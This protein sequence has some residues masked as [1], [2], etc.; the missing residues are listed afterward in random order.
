MQ[1][2]ATIILVSGEERWGAES[3]RA[4][5]SGAG[6]RVI[7]TEVP[8]VREA[9]GHYHP[10]LVVANLSGR[11]A[12]DLDLCRA[13]RRTGDTPVLVIGSPP[14]GQSVADLLDAGADGYVCHP[15]KAREVL[16]RVQRLL[17][18]AR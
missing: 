17:A 7:A 10:S 18:R 1:S 5:L 3:V 4:E 6:Y 9:I 16:L 2:T 11:A 14:D 15:F 8:Q 12:A 13:V